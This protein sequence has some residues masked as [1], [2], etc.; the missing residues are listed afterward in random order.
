[1]GKGGRVS[2]WVRGELKFGTVVAME[3]SLGE[4][5]KYTIRW[6]H[7]AS[8]DPIEYTADYVAQYFQ[9]ADPMPTDPEELEQWL[10]T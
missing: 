3:V 5:T 2:C 9:W 6:E 4:P 7:H 10:S 8:P 1:M